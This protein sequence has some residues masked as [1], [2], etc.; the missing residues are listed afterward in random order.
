MQRNRHCLFLIAIVFAALAARGAYVATRSN[1]ISWADAKDY[2]SIA[3]NLLKGKGFVSWEGKRAGRAPGYPLFL[4]GCYALGL[5]TPRAIHLIQAI[6]GAATCL[7]IWLLGRQLYGDAVGLVAGGICAIYPFFI[8]YTGTVLSE[9]LFIAGFVGFLLCL[10][11]A[12]RRLGQSLKKRLLW[13]A[14]AG[15]VAGLL[16]LLKSSLLL[17]PFFLL[18]FWLIQAEARKKAALSWVVMIAVMCVALSPWVIRNYRLYDRLIPTTLQVGPS[19]YEANSPFATG[20]PAMDRID[21]VE[22]RGGRMM[23]EVEHNAF[24]KNEA[25]RYIREHPGRFLALAFEKARRFW[26][27]VPNY[28]PSNRSAQKLYA[29]TSLLSYFPIMLLALLGLVLRRG[30][31][32]AL[33]LLLPPVVYFAALHM[34]FVGST[35]YRTPIMLFIIL[36]AA[37]GLETMWERLRSRQ[38]VGEA[39]ADE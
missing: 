3:R 4:A 33:L 16:V 31:T 8:Y 20:G 21:W 37:A 10:V 14:A 5:D 30:Q 34:V 39:A 13:A 38:C 11:H 24:F 28:A 2:D 9:T 25:V 15:L 18:P 32:K 1:E 22:V 17:F 7:L 36:I 29:A 35:R 6:V 27:V 23:S 12:G 26:N 19:L